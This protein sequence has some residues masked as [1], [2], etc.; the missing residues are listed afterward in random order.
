M[1]EFL[2][3]VNKKF[4]FTWKICPVVANL[5][6]LGMQVLKK[7]KSNLLLNSLSIYVYFFKMQ[8]LPG[9]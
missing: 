7:G 2:V 8:Y 9:K 1:N 6:V 3:Y 4:Y 5:L